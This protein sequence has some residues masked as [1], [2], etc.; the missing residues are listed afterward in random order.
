MK[1]RRLKPKPPVLPTE[2]IA[3]LCEGRSLLRC[4]I[5]I[6]PML[7]DDFPFGASMIIAFFCLA[8][9]VVPTSQR[10]LRADCEGHQEQPALSN[11]AFHAPRVDSNA[12]VAVVNGR[13]HVV[14]CRSADNAKL[15]MPLPIRVKNSESE[16]GIG[17]AHQPS[18]DLRSKC[19]N[20]FISPRHKNPRIREVVM[21]TAGIVV[22]SSYGMTC[23]ECNKLVIAP[24]SS[25]HVTNHEVRHFWSC[26]NCG[27]EIEMTVNP[28]LHAASNLA[29][30]VQWS[31]VA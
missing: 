24:R 29:K 21:A 3:Y 5:S 1:S 9:E 10:R 23:T 2:R 27:H 12:A 26:E 8:V 31:V 22:C 15:P 17:A 6:R 20:A 30:G 4:G 19:H 18:T 13:M 7:K 28:R 14:R 16:I 25:A 11:R